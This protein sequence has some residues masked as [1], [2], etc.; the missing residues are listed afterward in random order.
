MSVVRGRNGDVVEHA[1]VVHRYIQSF[2]ISCCQSAN[3]LV[4]EDFGYPVL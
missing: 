2:E 4:R 3:W 1:V